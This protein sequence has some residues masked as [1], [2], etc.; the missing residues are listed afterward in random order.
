MITGGSPS[1]RFPSLVPYPGFCTRLTCPLLPT[2][3]LNNRK[4]IQNSV[5]CLQQPSLYVS[6][7]QL[8]PCPGCP[9][10]A[11]FIP[12]KTLDTQRRYSMVDLTCLRNFCDAH[13]PI[14]WITHGWAPRSLLALSLPLSFRSAARIP[15][16]LAPA[17]YSS[18]ISSRLSPVGSIS[19]T[20][21]CP[22]HPPFAPGLVRHPRVV[23]PSWNRSPVVI[24]QFHHQ[25]HYVPF[26]RPP[27]P[28][29][30]VLTA[31]APFLSW[32]PL[33]L[34]SVSPSYLLSSFFPAPYCTPFS[35]K[36][37]SSPLNQQTHV[38][39]PPF[40]RERL[41]GLQ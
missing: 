11:P 19:E 1:S 38:Q 37:T 5:P 22:S 12:T 26:L 29:P 33:P 6:P 21:L 23:L 31:T 16:E 15:P 20:P 17:S 41:R 25:V 40:F 35:N 13:F 4:T 9:L 30:V 24:G 39:L 32:S 36:A 27:A 34:R 10:D 18:S 28:V 7:T 14:V 3:N 8:V 2:Y